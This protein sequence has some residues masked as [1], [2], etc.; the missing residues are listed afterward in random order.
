VPRFFAQDAAKACAGGVAVLFGCGQA[1]G[2][3]PALRA[4]GLEFVAESAVL[5]G[6]FVDALDQCPLRVARRWNWP[7]MPLCAGSSPARSPRSR[8]RARLDIHLLKDHYGDWGEQ[9]PEQVRYGDYFW[10]NRT[11]R[12]SAGDAWS[13]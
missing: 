11:P 1:V 8:E 9:G 5:L 13:G 10:P 3:R 7:S 6:E 4:P 12:G 2:Q